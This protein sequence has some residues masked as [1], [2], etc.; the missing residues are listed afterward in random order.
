MTSAAMTRQYNGWLVMG[1]ALKRQMELAGK[2]ESF[3][4]G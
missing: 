2:C 3:D 4:T 1:K